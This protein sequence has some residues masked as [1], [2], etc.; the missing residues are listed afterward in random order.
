VFASAVDWPGWCRSG[1]DEASALEALFAAAP[2]YARALGRGKL[3]FTAPR[4]VAALRIV[5]RLRGDATTDYGAPGAMPSADEQA[6]S[7]ADLTRT[8][9]ILRA[10]W[11]A[12][13]GAAKSARSKRLAKGPRGGGRTLDAIVRHVVDAEAG[14]LGALGWKAPAAPRTPV[15]LRDAVLDGLAASARGEIP[16]RGPR[17][18]TRWKPRFFARRLAW[19]ALDH[20]WEI[21]DRA[22]G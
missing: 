2:R 8:G 10:C 12:V 9:A 20:A 13:D 6:M 15:R 21:E 5:E 22:R 14:Y 4:D 7:A 1:R 16:A 3:G 17:G 19:H 18:G 11:R